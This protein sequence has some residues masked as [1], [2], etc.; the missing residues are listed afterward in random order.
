MAIKKSNQKNQKLHNTR[1]ASKKSPLD[2][3][4]K[5]IIGNNNT[6]NKNIEKVFN[7]GSPSQKEIKK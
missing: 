5:Q 3:T 4:L 2:K 6:V 7:D 1:S